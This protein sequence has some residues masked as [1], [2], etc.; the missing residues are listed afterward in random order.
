VL[1]GKEETAVEGMIDRLIEIG[2]CYGTKMN[3]DKTEVLRI[4]K[5]QSTLQIMIY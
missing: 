4:S 3:V 5:Q 2:R 1:L